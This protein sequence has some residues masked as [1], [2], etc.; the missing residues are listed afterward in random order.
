MSS[1][2][3]PLYRL[4]ELMLEKE[5]HIL[6][7]D[8]L[9]DDE[10]IGD[11]VKSIQ[12]DSPYQQMLLEGVLTE[13]VR[14]EKLFVSFT[15]EG[16]FHYLLGEVIYNQ[17]E[18]KEPI[19]LKNIFD[20]NKL[21]GAREGVVLCL[22][23]DIYREDLSRL[24]WLIDSLS[25]KREILIVPLISSLKSLGV[26]KTLNKLL[27]NP[28]ENDWELLL[29]VKS[30][31][32]K[33]HLFQ[34]VDE[35]VNECLLVK[36]NKIKSS[37]IFCLLSNN[38]NSS[39]A[40]LL[41]ESLI[42]ITP[43]FETNYNLLNLIGDVYKAYSFN[44]YENALIFY[45]KCLSNYLLVNSTIDDDY[46]AMLYK[47]I[48][49]IHYKKNEFIPAS[50]NFSA[51]LQIYMN[52]NKSDN[53]EVAD[54]YQKFGL[55][56][57]LQKKSEN[58]I[59]YFE[60]ALSIH[61]NIYGK[62]NVFVQHNYTYLADCWEE[63]GEYDKAIL[64]HEKAFVIAKKIKDLHSRF[65]FTD[66]SLFSM[67]NCYIKAGKK[68]ERKKSFQ[69]AIELY[70]KGIE[71]IEALNISEN[72]YDL[73]DLF[74]TI[75]VFLMNQN[76]YRSAIDYLLRC[77]VIDQEDSESSFYIA[78]CYEKVNDTTNAYNY[79]LKTI[80]I[81]ESVCFDNI[82][83]YINGEITYDAKTKINPFS[84]A[85]KYANILNR[86]DDLPDWMN[87]SKNDL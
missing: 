50:E 16:Y 65:E 25:Q 55:L 11:L 47:K 52:Q 6:P 46:T 7:V 21:N 56:Y 45:Q 43:D 2:H 63:K 4:A 34:L 83:H 85:K 44:D 73:R 12:I 61:L 36:N 53:N 20:E 71:H 80:I 74:F 10:Q 79:Y 51:S 60:K 30:K 57:K 39:D 54:L 58:A 37:V 33:L 68:A 26:K 13:S 78:Q 72:N 70:K 9:F 59:I 3:L 84:K 49:Y 41:L 8:L 22:I 87:T 15:V 32:N 67:S 82:E 62:V 81:F 64:F 40:E 75:A 66:F 28:T 76:E 86:I 14:D 29:Q 5:Q 38:I 35:L 48:G 1:N 23:K 27:A 18:G 69:K 24:I 19:I 17:T 42:Q 31:L 77:L